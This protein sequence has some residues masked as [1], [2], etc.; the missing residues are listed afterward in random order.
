MKRQKLVILVLT[1]LISLVCAILY[2]QK[3]PLIDSFEA[4]SYDFR[5]HL[6]GKLPPNPAIVIVAIDDKSVGELGRFPWTRTRFAQFVDR[7]TAAGAKA[8]YLDAFFPEKESA[9]AD[10]AFA[11]ALRRSGITSL[12][13]YF[14]FNKDGSIAH[15]TR[16]IPLL[17]E[18]ARSTP[19]INMFPDDDGVVRS[20]RLLIDDGQ[21]PVAS[22]SLSA[23]RTLLGAKGIEPGTLH[24]DLDGHR[25]PTD[26]EYYH[27]V[28]Y[29]GEPGTYPRYSFS[30]VL[31]GR[32]GEAQL[33]DKIVLVGAT[34]LGIYDMRVTPFSNNSPGVEVHANA[35]DAMTRGAFMRRGGV[36]TLFDLTAIAVLGALAAAI[37]LQLRYA[38]SLPLITTLFFG[39]FGLAYS[40]FLQGMWVSVVYP[41]LSLVFSFFTTVYLRFALLDRKAR[42]VKEMFSSYVSKHVV[43]RLI[44]D[45]SQARVGGDTRVLTLLFSDVENYTGF[46]EKLPPQEVLRILNEYLAEMTNLVMAH[47]GTL[48]K[49]IGDGIM[50]FWGAPLPQA[51]HA[52]LAVD[53]A[54][55]MRAKMEE[56]RSRW[57]DAGQA[58][59]SLRIGVNTGEVTVGN[60]GVAGKKM[61]YTAIGD[62]VNL[63]SR[64]ESINKLYGTRL[65]ISDATRALL[66]TGK[67]HLRRID[68]ARLKGKDRATE[69]YEVSAQPNPAFAP[70][71]EALDL[72]RQCR[73]HE[74]QELFAD[75]AERYNDP[76]SRLF[77]TRCADYIVNPP[78]E[79]WDGIFTALR[80]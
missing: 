79:G 9:A 77:Q 32:V 39:Y 49:F 4:K 67:Y 78:P 40:L 36:E 50:V 11:D 16:S 18:A 42:E 12:A 7:A 1:L 68:A 27:L 10:T 15:V 34:S 70:Y 59:L 33:K 24:I 61:E 5:F 29:I 44:Q 63:A 45:P 66:P 17:S 46:S 51:N 20:I 72:F 23:A 80:K 47:E 64:L 75:L 71:E 14:E 41:E 62:N 31:A 52:E 48:D 8:I 28:N 69:L 74:A 26:G 35:I 30:D 58:P 54:L 60:I 55:R 57:Q 53:C 38:I 22:M 25:I 19:H 73:F 37:T 56:L 3:N 13:I 65:L 76:P 43:D 21:G 6:R 2:Y